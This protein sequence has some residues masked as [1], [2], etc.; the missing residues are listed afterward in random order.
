MTEPRKVIKAW[1]LIRHGDYMG[2][3]GEPPFLY[4]TKRD[5][6]E[7]GW[8]GVKLVRVTLTFHKSKGR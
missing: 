6:L 7:A 2:N 8:E 3:C 1:A 4:S 5:A